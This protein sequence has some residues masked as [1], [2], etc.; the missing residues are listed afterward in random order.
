MKILISIWSWFPLW[1]QTFLYRVIRPR[2]RVG[3]VAIIFDEQKRILLCEHTYRKPPQWG[4][5][6][7]GLE[8]GEDPEEGMKRELEEETGFEVRVERLLCAD[9]AKEF[10]HISLVYLC[11]VLG[12]SF[13]PNIEISRV[14]FYPLDQ[15]PELLPTERQLLEKMIAKN[16][17]QGQTNELA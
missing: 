11:K 6:A 8:R 17:I 10:H 9:S 16:L 1:L 4:L 12:G 2:F 14:Q 13:T 7:G 5:P 3:V 15:L